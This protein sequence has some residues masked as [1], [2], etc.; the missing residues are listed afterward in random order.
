MFQKL[1]AAFTTSHSLLC[2]SACSLPAHHAATPLQTH[3]H[4]PFSKPLL[5]LL[6]HRLPLQHTPFF[7]PLHTSLLHPLPLPLP[8]MPFFTPPQANS[9]VS[10]AARLTWQRRLRMALDAAKGMV[11]LHN[12]KPTILHRDLKSPNLFVMTNYTVKVRLSGLLSCVMARGA[13]CCLPA[14]FMLKVGA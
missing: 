4:N 7:K 13:R 8:Q 10:L 2:P 1:N 11:H 9:D 12:H 3:T 5:T 6:S 14:P